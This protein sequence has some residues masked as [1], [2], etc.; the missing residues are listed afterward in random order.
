MKMTV[1]LNWRQYGRKYYADHSKAHRYI[2][3]PLVDGWK[4]E[5]RFR[6]WVTT[7]GAAHSLADAQA[8]AQG[9]YDGFWKRLAERQQRGAP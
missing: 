6:S 3:S 1:P 4:A 7:L 5:R 2:L 9:D 8:I